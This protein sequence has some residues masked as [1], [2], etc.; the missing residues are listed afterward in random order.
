MSSV[1]DKPSERQYEMTFARPPLILVG[2]SVR[3]LAQS[4]QKAGW[5][6][7]AADLFGDHDLLAST[8]RLERIGDVLGPDQAFS[9]YPTG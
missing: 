9:T 1:R 4:A 8:V 3:S 5:S 2:A 6:V 7:Y